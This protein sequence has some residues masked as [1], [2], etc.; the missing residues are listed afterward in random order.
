M[1]L[2]IAKHSEELQV[3]VLDGREV[4]GC[5]AEA[6]VQRRVNGRLLQGRIHDPA[7]EEGSDHALRG[8]ETGRGLE[9]RFC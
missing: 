6:I 2:S 9:C 5:H 1:R 8:E 4:A 7:R 3:R